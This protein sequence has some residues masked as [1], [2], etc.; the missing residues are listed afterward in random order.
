MNLLTLSVRGPSP[1]RPKLGT[2]KYVGR[3][4]DGLIIWRHTLGPSTLGEIT[5]SSERVNMIITRIFLFWSL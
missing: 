3:R 4:H 2:L 5:S 1:R